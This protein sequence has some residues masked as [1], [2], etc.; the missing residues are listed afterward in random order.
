MAGTKQIQTLSVEASTE[1][2]AEVRDFVAAHAEK[3][4]LSQKDISEIRLAVDEAYTNII[5][6]AYK[7]SNSKKVNIEIGS[8]S[9]Q[10]WI[11]LMDEGKGFDPS[12]Y[13]EPDLIKRIKQKKRGGMGVYLIRKLMDQ[14]QYTRKGQT[15]EIRMVKNL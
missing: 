11:S 14:V 1:H 9:N 13:S 6:H 10:L 2:L 5:K 15:N 12:S 4:G 8:D 7:N 3:I